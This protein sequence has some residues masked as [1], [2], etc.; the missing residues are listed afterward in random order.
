M[1]IEQ[2]RKLKAGDKIEVVADNCCHR[3]I[4]GRVLTIKL[5]EHNGEIRVNEGSNYL[6]DIDVVKSDGKI[7]KTKCVKCG[8]KI[9]EG[10]SSEQNGENYCGNCFDDIFGECQDCG[11][12]VNNDEL[13]SV[14]DGGRNVCGICIDNYHYC[15]GC[16]SYFNDE[17]WDNGGNSVCGQCYENG[18]GQESNERKYSDGKEYASESGRAYAVEIETYYPNMKERQKLFDLPKEIG[19]TSDGSLGSRGIELQTP[20]LT[21][22]KGDELLKKVCQQLN[23]DKFIVDRTCGLHV[24]FDTSD[25]KTTTQIRNL[26][27]FYLTFENVIY[28]FLPMSRR[29]NRFCIPLSELY[30]L[31]EVTNLR[32]IDS[33]EKMWYREQSRESIDERKNEK[34]DSS[35]YA[36]YNFHSMLANGHIESRHHSGTQDYQKIKNWTELN[37]II[38]DNILSG[39]INDE[40]IIR[41]KNVFDL[42]QKTKLFF[43]MLGV[44]K[45]LQSYFKARQEKFAKGTLAKQ[46]LCAE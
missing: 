7:D 8:E 12:F 21:G 35:R 10:D 29:I 11:D 6:T 2:V 33:I 39:R 44:N 14:C 17:T 43:E 1:T 23:N 46:E 36:G 16:G 5:I 38:L 30:H 34:Y 45:K 19:I 28:S 22:T 27:L 26:I 9:D 31:K 3:F 15:N 18:T 32:D 42:S 25:F 24:H 20:K 41:I 37:I 4:I 13:R 40:K